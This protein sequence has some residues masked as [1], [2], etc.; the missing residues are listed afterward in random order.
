MDTEELRDVLGNDFAFIFNAVSPV[1][2]ELELEKTAKLL[3][4][5]TGMGWMAVTLAL[6]N[7]KVITGEPENDD[8]EYAKQNWL[9]SAK[10]AKVEHLITYTPFNAEDMPFED[11]SFD[12][13]FI[14]GALHHINDKEAALK[15]S[16]RVLKSNG[17][18]CI[19]EPTDNLLS[20]IRKN[21]FPSHPDPVDPRNFTHDLHLSLELIE[22]QFYNTYILR[23]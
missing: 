16:A 4:I 6:N 11:A 5:G 20:I 13:I 23:K 15:E 12:A 9:E 14:L 19:F 7:Y 2:Q 17:I 3:D 21:R 8:S 10:K 1:L 18:I 22:G